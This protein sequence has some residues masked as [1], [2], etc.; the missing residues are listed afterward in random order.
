MFAWIFFRAADISHAYHFILDMVSG[1][2]HKSSYVKTY[3]M[4]HRIGLALPLLIVIFILI[5]WRGREQQYAIA[6]MGLK[7]KKPI[8]YAFYYT[9]IVIIFLYG[10]RE[11]QFIYFQF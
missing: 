1:F 11:Q 8:R 6:K 10:G 9:I 5:E 4:M 7:W 2:A 3:I